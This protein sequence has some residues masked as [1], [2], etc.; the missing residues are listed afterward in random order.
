MTY[1]KRSAVKRKCAHCHSKFESNHKS[2]LYCCQS[3]NT[4]ACRARRGRPA[5]AKPQKP[6]FGAP[7]ELSAQTIGVVTLGAT[8]G[9]LAAQGGTYLAQQLT[10]GG[11]DF[12]LL[13]AEVRHLRQELGFVP[14]LPKPP[15]GAAF[16]PAALRTAT[17]PVVQLRVG[18][19]LVPFVRLS[20]H[21]H[22]LYHHPEQGV[23]LWEEGPGKHSRVHSEQQLAQLAAHLPTPKALPAALSLGDDFFGAQ[24]L[25]DMQQFAA[26]E[27]ATSAAMD[28]AFRVMIAPPEVRT[29]FPPILTV[30]SEAA[31]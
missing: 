29:D 3:C 30:E 25:A 26:Q 7:L 6:A 10:Q 16:L 19:G 23:V 4:L 24:F 31:P 14:S 20:Y 18:D 28:A 21:G 12:E 15:H 22:V 1:H 2:R 17:A 13:R 9:S 8:L 11:S 27:A 5:V